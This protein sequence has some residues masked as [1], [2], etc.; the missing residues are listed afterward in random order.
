MFHVG[1]SGSTLIGDML[2]QHPQ[3]YWSGEIYKNLL[4]NNYNLKTEDSRNILYYTLQH[5]M[6]KTKKNQWLGL[7]TKFYHVRYFKEDLQDYI[8]KIKENGVCKFV[9]L[10]RK[11]YLR[12]IVSSIAASQSATW[13]QPANTKSRLTKVKINIE[14]VR[15]DGR[16]K[17][18][19]DFLQEYESDFNTIKE[20]IAEREAMMLTYE[21]DV[22]VSPT[23]TCSKVLQLLDLPEH[24]MKT[25]YGKTNPFP[26]YEIITNYDEV[27][28]Y[29][30]GTKFEWM[31]YA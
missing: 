29:L 3:I 27:A 15:I 25:R 26:L 12:K 31:L 16:N 1:R 17:P 30:S 9:V 5:E 7:E 19:I 21:E 6:E 11:N 20:L 8:Q 14:S 13:H 10:E 22:A 18:L 24:G 28:D 2:D 4:K 23:S